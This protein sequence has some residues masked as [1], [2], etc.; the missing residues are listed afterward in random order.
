[1]GTIYRAVG[2]DEYIKISVIEGRDIVEAAR[3]IHHLRCR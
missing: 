1:M 3:Q 2:G